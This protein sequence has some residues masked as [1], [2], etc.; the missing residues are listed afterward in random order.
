MSIRKFIE[1]WNKREKLGKFFFGLHNRTE[2]ISRK[3]Q[4]DI[5]SSKFLGEQAHEMVF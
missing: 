5:F 3:I 1:S 2:F 4:K